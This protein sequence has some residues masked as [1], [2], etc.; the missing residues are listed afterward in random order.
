MKRNGIAM[1]AR[2]LS[3]EDEQWQVASELQADL[4]A[5]LSKF[6]QDPPNPDEQIEIQ[7]CRSFADKMIKLVHDQIA[8]W[9]N[10]SGDASRSKS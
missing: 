4:W 3:G 2:R 10:A 8:S 7:R 6:K 1:K 5:E 9:A